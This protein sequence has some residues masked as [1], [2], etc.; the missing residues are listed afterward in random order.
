[1]SAGQSGDP[2][3]ENALTLLAP[4]MSLAIEAGLRDCWADGLDVMVYETHRTN[5]LQQLYYA[6]GRTV[7]PPHYTVTNA[8]S[9]EYSWHFFG[10]AAD[11]IS[12][13]KGW[14]QP[15]S[16]FAQMATHFKSHGLKWGG[17]WKMKDLPHIQWGLCKPSPSNV[18][19]QLFAQGGNAAVWNVVRAL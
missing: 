7:I 1:M 6:R 15:E 9:A 18:A 16:W 10:L 14:D 4:K 3:V 17:D 13:S 12:K 11:C 19:R 8:Q 5:Q 2:Q